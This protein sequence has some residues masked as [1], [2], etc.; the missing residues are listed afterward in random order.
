[1]SSRRTRTSVSTRKQALEEIRRMREGDAVESVTSSS[2]LA[3]Y[4][5]KEE[6]IYKAVTEQE[7]EDLVRQRRQGL[8]F[9]ENDD[10]EMGY[11]DDG[12]E[13]FFESDPDDDAEARDDD[14]TTSKKRS[15]GALSSSY[16][17]RAKK[18]QRAKLGGGGGEG[19]KI[20][21]IFFS[22]STGKKT[23]GT[24]GDT[25]GG[26]MTGRLRAKR[27]ID[28]DSLLDDLTSNP[29]ES[30]QTYVK[31]M[32]YTTSSL[33][34]SSG[35][36]EFSMRKP[37][38]IAT[39]STLQ[40]KD[41]HEEETVEFNDNSYELD[42]ADELM[43]KARADGDDMMERDVE[44]DGDGDATMNEKKQ[45]LAVKTVT[46]KKEMM[47]QKAREARLQTSAPAVR[48]LAAPV[49]QSENVVMRSVPSNEVAEWWQVAEDDLNVTMKDVS[50]AGGGECEAPPTASD[51][52]QMYWMDAVEV[53]ER[54]GKIYL[55][56]KMKTL[57]P[58]G[59]N[60][61]PMYRSCCVVVN[62][63]QRY[64]YLVPT[65]TPLI[66]LSKNVRQ[67]TWMKMH[68]EIYNILIPSCITSKRDQE[69]FR[70]KLV[71]R[72][73][74]FEEANIPRGKSL[75]LKV[76]Y[77]AKYPAPPS[78]ICSHGGKTFSRICGALTRPLEN[79]LLTRRLLGPG[80][81]EIKNVRKCSEGVSFCKIEFETF[82]PK[83]VCST[84]GGM[85][86]PPLTV[87]SLSLKSVC[88][89]NTGKHEVVALSAI[90]ESG[91]SAE[92]SGKGANGVRHTLSHFTAI[93]PLDGSSG[94]PQSYAEAA[95]KDDRFGIKMESGA[96]GISNERLRV[97][98]NE[99]VMLSYFLTRVQL[100]DPD[101]IVGHN[102]HK[103]ALE[104]LISRID[105]FKLGGLWSKLTRL[106]R[107]RLNPMN[108]GEGW[109]EYRMDDMVNGRLCCDTYV[110]SKELLPS[111]NNY[112]LSYLVERLLHKQRLDVEMTEVP[113]ILHGGPDNFV[114][115]LRH[116]LDDAMFVLHLMHKLEILPLSKQLS[117]LCGYLWT[118]TLEANKRAER[119]EYLLLHEF[120]R[121]KNKFIV[122]EKFKTRSEA[123]K[124]NKRREASYAGGMVFAPK[125]G[126]YDNY[127]VLLDFM[128]LYPSIIRE[129]NI[130]FTTVERQI[131]EDVPGA[132]LAIKNKTKSRLKPV[133]QPENDDVVDDEDQNPDCADAT[134]G[135]EIP[136][137]PSSASEPGILPAVI[138]R[139]LESRKQVKQQLKIE[140]KA[141]NM[142]KANLLDIR[143]KAIK[144]TANSMYGC[145][146]FRFSRFY[147]KPIAAL[148]TS[149]G[150]HTLQR[151]KEVAEQECGYDVI[152]GDTDSIMVNSRTDSLEEAKRI[153]REIQTQC[154]KHFRLLELE[155]DF[156]FKRILLLNKKKY[157][158]LVLK[159]QPNCEPT[160]EKEVKGLDMVRRDWCV[161]SK[162]VGNEI[163]DFILSGNSRDD[164]VESIHEHLEQVAE[165]MRS[166]KEPVEQYVI[167]KSLNKQP[168]QYP[169]RAKQYHV[170]VAI[171]LRG[172]GK[173]V[174]VGM[175]IPY[176]LCKEEEPGSGRR[177]YHPDE[178]KRAN[179]KLN[180][181][182]EW[183]LESQVHPP[184]N[185]LC[186]YIEGTS[187]SQLAHFLG[188]DTAKFSHSANHFS[189]END[190]G[191]AIPSV[192]QTDADRF[193]DCVPLK[194]TCDRCKIA[195]DFSGVFA[196]AKD[197]SL[198]SGLLCPVCKADFWG[199]DQ[200]G[201]YGNV[202][203]DLQAV[204]SNRLHNA[205][206]L[207]AKKYYEAWTICSDVM[208][209][210]RTQKQSLRG[211]GN[212]CS[213]VGC[214]AI[215]S[216]E[217]PDS[218]LYT[219][220]KY[221]ESLF[222]VERAQKKIR[223]Q[224]E[225]VSGIA[226]EPP[227]LPDGHRAVLQKLLSQAEEVRIC[228][229]TS[230]AQ[231]VLLVFNTHYTARLSIKMIT[232]GSSPRFGRLCSYKYSFLL[233]NASCTAGKCRITW[234]MVF[235]VADLIL[236]RPA[237]SRFDSVNNGAQSNAM[238]AVV[239][240]HMSGK[241]DGL[242]SNK[243]LC[244]DCQSEMFFL[245][246]IDIVWSCSIIECHQ[247]IVFFMSRSTV[248]KLRGWGAMS[249]FTDDDDRQ[250]VQLAL[251]SSRSRRQ[252]LWDRI[253]QQMKGTKKS[254]EALRQRLKTLKR[255]HGRNLENF[256]VWYFRKKFATK[257]NPQWLR[258]ESANMKTVSEGDKMMLTLRGNQHKSQ[259]PGRRKTMDSLQLNTPSIQTLMKLNCSTLPMSLQTSSY[260]SKR[261]KAELQASA[262]ALL[263]LANVAI[264]NLRDQRATNT[265]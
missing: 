240:R 37:L 101:V 229:F 69:I 80:W 50:A 244:C 127:V 189:E 96:L 164:V 99:R 220:L 195:S 181:D 81:I 47:L 18:M 133:P 209:K 79:F 19:Q 130:C 31:P 93:R 205:T 228:D 225:R 46:S 121:S 88:N 235:S 111:Q 66:E 29:T 154:N 68:E 42:D 128:S 196:T 248:T 91:I 4:K 245:M 156:I 207:A 158:A 82:D 255:T 221:F 114:K 199:F 6:S 43:E 126:L 198:S 262:P 145:L 216:L 236:E 203:D 45:M 62:N 226:T 34:F 9:V 94:F 108:V 263:L 188:L 77:S 74:A 242:G 63:L 7:Y 182:V 200:E 12:E 192:L 40:S 129:Y 222:D 118:R 76:K 70:T 170:Q 161:I 217:Y 153:G 104:L 54:P 102:L 60:E 124:L 237:T 241:R 239:C 131:A 83:N 122:P 39:N 251:I 3:Q 202:G 175:H 135:S 8:P 264:R 75:F 86:P 233:T 183:Y 166:G 234:K 107:G 174:G 92:G 16:V 227:S 113:H 184:V 138:K 67:E 148:I 147:A 35:M 150:R 144:L 11:Y 223:E 58:D 72:N 193:K 140:Q 55:I 57:S 85:T 44:R 2:R 151:A 254:K 210:T 132:S 125:K 137:L 146:G 22:T 105:N 52:I 15:A 180:I 115:F 260:Y 169:D 73:Y 246:E 14:N 112:T 28:L 259:E 261:G 117:N 215:T 32:S 53:R 191:S 38:P 1:M 61:Q 84:A 20:T 49:N 134:A 25:R 21:N 257:I 97:E 197:S 177:A 5:P 59:L 109:N 136:A 206:R 24:D 204:L 224:K 194:I 139:L 167:T 27:D 90:L 110:S 95:Q 106:R 230:Y 185:R 165:R 98:I 116:T 218:A 250:L 238:N 243:I 30:R 100:E 152:Y 253:T 211:N 143:Q 201:V 155:V 173:T 178:V 190:G 26:R 51:S 65:G 168:E 10:G 208:C 159:E 256:P 33:T 252:I 258:H 163:L 212:I 172:L 119:I 48:T 249:D 157:A 64:M 171:A 265:G 213:A 120:S 187:S 17:R 162:A 142:E 141:G 231:Y 232:T 186:A 179:G 160:F 103:Y 78:D 87:M 123:D 23:M 89:P 13:Q 219:Q 41:E 149:T 214:R 71:E 36:S 176:V 56:G 247:N